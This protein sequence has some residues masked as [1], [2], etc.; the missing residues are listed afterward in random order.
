MSTSGAS[1]LFALA[2]PA[3]LEPATY[4]LGNCRSIQLSYG[5]EPKRCKFLYQSAMTGKVPGPTLCHWLFDP[6]FVEDAMAGRP[7]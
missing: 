1:A 5:T 2:I 6:Q 4:S 3:G 7:A